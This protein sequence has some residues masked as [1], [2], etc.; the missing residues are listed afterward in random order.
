MPVTQPDVWR[1]APFDAAIVEDQ[2]F[3]KVL[4][5]RGAANFKGPE[6][7]D[8]NALMAI[9]QVRGKLPVNVIFVAEGD[10]ERMDVG[11]RNFVRDHHDLFKGADALINEGGSQNG[12]SEGSVFVQLT[13]SGKAWGRGPVESDI[14]GSNKRSVDSP[15]WRQIRMLASLVSD[16][17]NTPKIDGWMEGYVPPDRKTLDGIRKRTESTTIGPPPS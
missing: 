11:L 7:V 1:V 12:S 9:R 6:M 13:T 5:A 15:A 2:G 10:E 16:D 3:K 4:I 17:G 14:Q 8:L